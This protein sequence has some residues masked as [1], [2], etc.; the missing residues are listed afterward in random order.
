MN[1]HASLLPRYRGA[2]PIRWAIA[3][4]ETETGV[5]L[6]QM[7]EGLDTGPVY[8]ARRISIGPDQNAGDVEKDIIPFYRQLR[9]D[10][11]G[12]DGFIYPPGYFGTE[13]AANVPDTSWSPPMLRNYSNEVAQARVYGGIHYPED[14]A[15]GITLGHLIADL[16]IARAKADGGQ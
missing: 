13:D 16:A 8:V 4:G 11:M 6:M 5:S 1:L 9:D 14:S 12:C 15:A 2:A 7:D 10:G 3:R